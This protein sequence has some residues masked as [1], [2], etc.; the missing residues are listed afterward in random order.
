M[1]NTNTESENLNIYENS[2]PWVESVT[3]N[4]PF[5]YV[6]KSISTAQLLENNTFGKEVEKG[7]EECGLK[8]LHFS[9]HYKGSQ[10][11]SVMEK[12][13]DEP[14]PH[15]VLFLHGWT[16]SEE[17][18]TNVIAPVKKNG[19]IVQRTMVEQ[20]LE[21]SG[22]NVIVLTM[23]GLGFGKT[24]YKEGLTAKEFKEKTTVEAYAKQAEL[25]LDTILD[26]DKKQALIVGHSYGGA[27]CLLLAKD[28]YDTIPISPAFVP[29]KKNVKQANDYVDANLI[30]DNGTVK[31]HNRINPGIVRETYAGLGAV[32][33]I[34]DKATS[35]TSN[36]K[37][38]KIIENVADDAIAITYKMGLGNFLMG[39]NKPGTGEQEAW[40]G[41]MRQLGPI[42]EKGLIKD[43]KLTSET[44]WNLAEGVDT[45]KLTLENLENMSKH[46]KASVLGAEDRL[47]PSDFSHMVRTIGAGVLSNNE[48]AAKRVAK[49]ASKLTRNS[50]TIPGAGH[51]SPVYSEIVQQEISKALKESVETIY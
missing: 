8:E 36:T 15:V 28:G 20:V 29:Q 12:L 40:D 35:L 5:P 39:R 46:V 30:E 47:A 19:R 42:H 17:M 25:L 43:P 26:V 22:D 32:V 6:T 49:A 27:A 41:V 37:I 1:P 18:Y 23:D 11:V 9:A 2:Q 7:M 24:D 13:H 48:N 44:M 33:G 10:E 14:P 4:E 45:S 21:N 16:G 34:A 38:G 3:H 31:D 50:Y 51:Y